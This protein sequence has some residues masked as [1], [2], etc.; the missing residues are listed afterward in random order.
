VSTISIKLHLAGYNPR[1]D[2]A[3]GNCFW[4][5]QHADCSSE[6]SWFSRELTS[7]TRAGAAGRGASRV[8]RFSARGSPLST[9]K[10]RGGH[11]PFHRTGYDREYEVNDSSHTA[12]LPGSGG[13][14]DPRSCAMKNPTAA[15]PA[16]A[17]RRAERSARFKKLS[18]AFGSVA[19]LDSDDSDSD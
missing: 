16:V 9:P 19:G 12:F 3:M 4:Y 5:E 8:E 1:R 10:G 15:A 13:D 11:A 14:G 2:S 6:G 17:R 7:H 18:W